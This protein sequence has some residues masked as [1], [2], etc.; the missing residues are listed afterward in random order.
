MPSRCDKCVYDC[1]C[2]V[3]CVCVCVQA[4]WKENH[5]TF[6]SQLKNLEATGLSTFGRSLKEAFDLLNVH[7][8]HTSIDHYGQVSCL[9][10]RSSPH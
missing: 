1:D 8:L 10:H 3:V 4:G 5:A 9:L 2:S 7:R 6:V